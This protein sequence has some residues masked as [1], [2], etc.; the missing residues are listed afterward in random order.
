M[1]MK[2]AKVACR[3]SIDK[4]ACPLHASGMHGEHPLIRAESTCLLQ[5]SEGME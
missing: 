5:I 2:L 1:P 4:S 3:F